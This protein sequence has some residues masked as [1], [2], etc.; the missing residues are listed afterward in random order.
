[1]EATMR[2]QH[3]LRPEWPGA[4][5]VFA[6]DAICWTQ[7]PSTLSGLR[8]QRM[9]WQVGLLESVRLHASM[10]GRARYGACA[11]L[12]MPYLA[13]FEATAPIIEVAGYAISILLLAIDP[14]AWPWVATL[15]LVTILFA[16]VQTMMALLVQETAFHGYSRRDL[17]RLLGWSLV[18]CAWYHPLLAVWR[19]SATV[20][21]LI[22]RRPGWGRIKRES[23]GEPGPEVLSPLTR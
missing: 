9:R 14:S 15:V 18:E 4:R 13:L 8:G 23:L 22:G 20:L 6:S 16:Q 21:L 2:L 11:M 5:I 19:L 17:T 7:A 10:L 1:M 3:R 12:S